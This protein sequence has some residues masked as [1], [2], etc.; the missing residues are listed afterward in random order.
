MTGYVHT[1]NRRR[2]LVAIQ[3]DSGFTI[4]E[5]LSSDPIGLNDQLEWDDDPLAQRST[6]TSR[7][8]FGTASTFRATAC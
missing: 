7:G 5:M 3:T 1:I 8:G 4:V 6:S 2:S